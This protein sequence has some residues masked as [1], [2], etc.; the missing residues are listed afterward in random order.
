MRDELNM[1]FEMDQIK[2]AIS[3]IVII[4]GTAAVVSVYVPDNTLMSNVIMGSIGAIA[5]LAGNE[6][7]KPK[8]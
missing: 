4:V 3:A 7:I 1:S 6:V 8:I 2:F 5:G